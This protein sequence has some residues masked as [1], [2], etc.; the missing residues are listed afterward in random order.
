MTTLQ[1][2]ATI[3]L[4]GASVVATRA[5]PFLLFRSQN[6]TPRFISFLSNYLP[7]AVF[8]MLVIY[9]L[10]DMP[11]TNPITILPRLIGILSCILLHIWRKNMLLTIAGGTAIYMLVLKL[12]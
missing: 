3:S 5:L 9:C 2:I 8:G 12:I 4:M 10:K 7:S 6:R 1:Q 11:L